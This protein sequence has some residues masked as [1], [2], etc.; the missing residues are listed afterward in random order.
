MVLLF[1]V[2]FKTSHPDKTGNQKDYFFPTSLT[3]ITMKPILRHDS[4]HWIVTTNARSNF[5]IILFG[6]AYLVELRCGSQHRS[7]KPNYISLHVK[8]NDLYIN[9][10]TYCTSIGFGFNLP[11]LNS[12]LNFSLAST[13][14]F[15]SLCKRRPKSLNMVEPPEKTISL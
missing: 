14:L 2:R 11:P 10:T 15:K 6:V 8:C 4:K 12:S 13:V 7:S 1:Q 5:F 9:C 3:P